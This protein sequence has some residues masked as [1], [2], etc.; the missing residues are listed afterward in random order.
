M[1]SH[2]HTVFDACGGMT[3]AALYQK[4]QSFLE[5]FAVFIQAQRASSSR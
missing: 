2:A 3:D 4:L 5:G 1:V